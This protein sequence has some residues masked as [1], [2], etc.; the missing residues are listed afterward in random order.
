MTR[1]RWRAVSG[2]VRALR[3]AGWE[4]SGMQLVTDVLGEPYTA[5]TIT[6][7]P[8]DEGPVVATLSG[9]ARRRA[10]DRKAVLHVHGFA[11]YFFQT[12][13]A[14][15]WTTAA[16]TSTPLDLR[17]YGRSLRRT[18]RRT[19]SPTCGELLPRARR[20]VAPDHR[21]R[22]PRPR[23]RSAPTPPAA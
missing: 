15:W 22:R 1:R 17:K 12:E 19:S 4:T 13:Y 5:E 9:A 16:T 11:D 8:D 6:L 14:E 3:A 20:G 10:D 2:S 7:P 23:R 21:A 18:R